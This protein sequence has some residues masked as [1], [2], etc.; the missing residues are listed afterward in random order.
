MMME[1]QA[2]QAPESLTSREPFVSAHR[3]ARVVVALFIGYI[4]LTA[5][6]MVSSLLWAG[7]GDMGAAVGQEQPDSHALFQAMLALLTLLVVLGLIVTFLMWLHRVMR[8]IPA[9]GNAKS[10]VEY[11]PGWAVGS[12]FIPVLNLFMPYRA[13][14]EAWAKSDP[15]IRTQD[16]IMFTPSP[17]GGLVLGWWLS[18]LAFNF[19]SRI[20][21][22]ISPEIG[23]LDMI[24]GVLGILAAVLAILVVSELDRRQTERS[25]HVT[26][27]AQTPPP[28]PLFTP[29]R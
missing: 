8:N 3:R 5:A 29:Q 1:Q 16:D 4:V 10:R 24:A 20:S 9:L 11:T 7:Q 14:R 13:V 26:Y 22:R 23:T 28:P 6:G 18:W 19:L 2:G 25:L 12:F 15:A 17:S 27:L 21:S